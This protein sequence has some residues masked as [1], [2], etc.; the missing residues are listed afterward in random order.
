MPRKREAS[1]GRGSRSLGGGRVGQP[2]MERTYTIID[3]VG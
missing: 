1:K 2:G 3:D